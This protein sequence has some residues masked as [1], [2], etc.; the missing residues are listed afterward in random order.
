MLKSFYVIL[1]SNTPGENNKTN[2]FTVSLPQK[3]Q[4][5]SNWCVGL[6]VISYP[7]TW[8][9]LGTNEPQAIEIE[10][11][12]GD[13]CSFPIPCL[14]FTTTLQLEQCISKALVNPE[15]IKKIS[16][17]YI[18]YLRAN[19]HIEKRISSNLLDEQ[20]SNPNPQT[21]GEKRY[22]VEVYK[23]ASKHVIFTF[24]REEGRFHVLIN[25]QFVSKILITEQ[26]SYLLGFPTEIS[27]NS[28]LANYTPDMHGGIS[29]LFVYAPNLI[30]PVII[31]N[32]SAPLLRIVS[33]RGTVDQT[34][35]EA[36]I[37]PQ[38]Y[39]VLVKEISEIQIEIRTSTGQLVPFD[40]GNCTL[41]LHFKKL[42]YI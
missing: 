28:T 10:W 16:R 11:Q 13:A 35:E 24:N 3:L 9:S 25:K 34:S 7:L 23:Q 14:R 27:N 40:Y 5:N 30:E 17:K 2:S 38:Y 19:S 21:F 22:W 26:L 18:E 15:P 8:P 6:S 20:F 1:P 29:S 31:G 12:S 36:Y 32:T 42:P 33:V 41:T 37:S 4:F 39:K